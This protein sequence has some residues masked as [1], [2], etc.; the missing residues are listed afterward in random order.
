MRYTA[1][2]WTILQ[3]ISDISVIKQ[4]Y[5]KREKSDFPLKWLYK[6]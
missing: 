6:C 5:T 1:T 3:D 2:N 4:N